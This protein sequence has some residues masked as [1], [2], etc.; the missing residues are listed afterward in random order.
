MEGKICRINFL[1][2]SFSRPSLLF[3]I[4]PRIFFLINRKN[5]KFQVSHI[6]PEPNG[7]GDNLIINVHAM[8]LMYG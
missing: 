6:Y 8:A 3:L 5:I 4:G 7:Q 1:W 2:I